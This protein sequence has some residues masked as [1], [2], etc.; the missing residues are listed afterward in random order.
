MKPTDIVIIIGRRESGKTFLI[1]RFFLP[2]FSSYVVDDHTGEYSSYGL[3]TSNPSL[4][5]HYRKVIFRDDYG[6]DDSFREMFRFIKLRRSNPKMRNTLVV[7][8]E[9]YTHFLKKVLPRPQRELVSR[10]RHYGLGIILATQRVYDINPVVYKQADYVVFF[11]TKEPK[12]LKWIESYIQEYTYVRGKRV[13]IP[14]VVRSLKQYYFV[15]F[16][17]R[18]DTMSPPTKL[19]A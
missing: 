2:Q 11:R 14:S 13:H 5:P 6:D 4:I 17:L 15:V 1:K 7:I 8:D 3:V 9:A 12:E 18:K 10:G 16:D 19:R